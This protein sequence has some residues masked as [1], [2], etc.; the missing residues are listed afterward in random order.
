MCILEN[1]KNLKTHDEGK[2]YQVIVTELEK[3]GYLITSKVINA[4]EY[5]SPQARHRIF[6]VATKSNPFQIPAG[7]NVTVP[8]R[9]I[10]DQ[11]V[12]Q[13]DINLEV[14]SLVK[15]ESKPAAHGKPC[16]LYDV[17]SKR[18][19]KGGRQGERVYSIDSAGITVCAS[20]GGPGA[21]TGLYLVGNDV[22]RLTVKETLGMFG[23]P[24][25]YQFPS[26][27]HEVSLFYLGNSIVV[28]VVL[29]FVPV[30]ADWFNLK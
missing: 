1:V 6:I 11:S 15:K 19:N 9:S 5:G 22:R 14:Y 12:H 20:S 24:E 28:N 17:I 4:A 26:A 25:S 10:I 16:V 29:A 8:V 13:N 18:S 30:V 3:R 7:S 21:K 2:T 23:F 27:T